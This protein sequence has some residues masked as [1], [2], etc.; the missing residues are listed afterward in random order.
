MS[1]GEAMS[2]N[3]NEVNQKIEELSKKFNKL[4]TIMLIGM[5][6]LGASA[7][8]EIAPLLV[9]GSIIVCASVLAQA[10]LRKQYKNLMK[11]QEE[12]KK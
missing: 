1:I 3:M 11:D 6:C 5:V 12:N 7:M 2:A 10:I 9:V 4:N 8:L